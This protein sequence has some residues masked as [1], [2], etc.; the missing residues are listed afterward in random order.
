MANNKK[1]FANIESPVN[2]F[3][4]T[5]TTETELVKVDQAQT[6]TAVVKKETKSKRLQLLVY[7]SIYE[8]CKRK[9]DSTGESVNEI[10]NEILK[11][12]FTKE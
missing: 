6:Q 1:G 3:I 2:K 7:P 4:S 12:Y 10:I 9:A 8:A 11:D 5:V